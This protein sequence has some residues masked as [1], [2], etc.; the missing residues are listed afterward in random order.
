MRL[1]GVVREDPSPSLP[2]SF[3]T[4]RCHDGT[5]SPLP[6]PS[7]GEFHL[8]VPRQ[9]L[10]LRPNAGRHCLVSVE[11]GYPGHLGELVV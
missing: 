10:G 2:P 9:K 6:T 7:T 4:R 5:G 11:V 3:P 8:L 1:P